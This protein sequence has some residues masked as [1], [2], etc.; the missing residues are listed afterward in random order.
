MGFLWKGFFGIL[1]EE[2]IFTLMDS[3][4]GLLLHGNNKLII[5]NKV[6]FS[7]LRYNRRSVGWSFHFFA[8]ERGPMTCYVTLLTSLMN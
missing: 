4:K 2:L 8:G 1:S 7:V 6:A 3:F 5:L